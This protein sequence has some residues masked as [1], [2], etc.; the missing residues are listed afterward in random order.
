MSDTKGTLLP[1]NPRTGQPER[2]N[3]AVHVGCLVMKNVLASATEAETGAC[4]NGTQDAVPFRNTLIEMGHPQPATLIIIDNQCAEGILAGTVK[5][6]RSKSMDMRY[7]WIKDRIAQG[8]FQIVWRAG[9]QNLADYFTK[10]H[11]VAHHVKMRTIY[12]VNCLAVRKCCKG[13]FSGTN[14]RYT[15]V[16]QQSVRRHGKQI[17]QAVKQ[18]AQSGKSKPAVIIRR[19]T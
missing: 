14:I 15:D 1:A 18:I 13:V 4:F 10:F 2:P 3:G 16:T 7:Y 19:L 17:A 9:K 6:R 12:L 5:Q 11:P 8:Q